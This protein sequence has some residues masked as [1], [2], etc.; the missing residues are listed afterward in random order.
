[1]NLKLPFFEISRFLGT[2]DAMMTSSTDV[3]VCLIVM[4]TYTAY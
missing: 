3:W 1:M 4:T 2:M